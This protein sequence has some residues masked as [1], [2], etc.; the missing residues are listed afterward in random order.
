MLIHSM[1]VIKRVNLENALNNLNKH[2]CSKECTTSV[3]VGGRHSGRQQ[4]FQGLATGESCD[5]FLPGDNFPY[6][7]AHTGDEHS[8]YFTMPDNCC[9]KG[10][11][12]CIAYLSIPEITTIEC[13]RSIIMVN[14][15]KC[16]IQIFKRDTVISF[17]DIDWQCM[18]SHLEVGDQVEVFVTFRHELVVKKIAVYLMYGESDDMEIEPLPEPKDNAFTRFIKK[19][20]MCDFW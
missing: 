18:I 19:I 11:A 13:L 3:K 2:V 1:Y 10:I 20:V 4:I 12:L 8:V 7:W 5:D 16:N 17:N 6:W 15:T 9:I 14:Y